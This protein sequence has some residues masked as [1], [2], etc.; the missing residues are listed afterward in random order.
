M[1]KIQIIT[2]PLN[3]GFSSSVNNDNAAVTGK[4]QVT[5]GSAITFLGRR[6]GEQ[7]REVAEV[8]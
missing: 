8:G 6:L 1:N 5:N 7:R 3:Q 2:K 4:V